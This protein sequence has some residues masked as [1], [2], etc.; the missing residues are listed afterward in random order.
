MRETMK[1]ISAELGDVAADQLMYAFL[2]NHPSKII[3]VM[4]SGKKER[5]VSALKALDT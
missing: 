3:P 4:G 2:L 1:E 5:V